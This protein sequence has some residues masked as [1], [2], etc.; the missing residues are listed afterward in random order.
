MCSGIKTSKHNVRTT[1]QLA[2]HACKN[3]THSSKT[4]HVKRI[5][6]VVTARFTIGVF[7]TFSDW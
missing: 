4:R 1:L 6:M 7:L 3:L 5:Q 2:Y